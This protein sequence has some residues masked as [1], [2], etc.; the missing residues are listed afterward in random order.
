M[1]FDK[2]TKAQRT[3]FTKKGWATRKANGLPLNKATNWMSKKLDGTFKVSKRGKYNNKGRYENEIF[4]DSGAE[5]DRY[6]QLL[7]MQGK[8]WIDQLE[9]HPVFRLVVNGVYV[10][11][12][13]A[14][15]KYRIKPGRMG[16]RV[17]YEDVKGM[18]TK[19]YAIKRQLM[20]ALFPTIEVTELL[21][22]RS[23]RRG[24]MVHRY[25]YLTAD[26]FN[27]VK[28]EP[29]DRQTTDGERVADR[30]DP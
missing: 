28:D 5:A 12:Y 17:L 13:E 23:S 2:W 20:K 27:S 10:C 8:G 9:V 18:V 4:F 14:D 29:D 15:F 25:R 26:Q 22:L 6:L 16:S 30:Q 7:E 1:S 3:A 21:L 19:D 11:R 24:S